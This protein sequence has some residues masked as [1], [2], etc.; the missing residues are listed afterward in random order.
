[1]KKNF[2]AAAMACI[3][4]VSCFETEEMITINADKS[5]TY[6]VT[7][8]MQGMMQQLSALAG[9]EITAGGIKEIR[10][11]VIYLRE[12]ADTSTSLTAEQKALL[13]DAK[14]AVHVDDT[15]DL[16]QFSINLPFA[17][18]DR[19]PQMKQQ[20]AQAMQQSKLA[21]QVM[22]APGSGTQ[23][24]SNPDLLGNPFDSA[25][26]WSVNGTTI[27]NVL[28]DSSYINTIL[29]GNESLA[30]MQQMAMLMGEISYITT[31]QL[32]EPVKDYTGANTWLS[33]D[34]KTIRFR[35]G[36]TELVEKPR[37]LEYSF[38]Y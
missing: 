26:S 34:K 30:S 23:T 6:T 5:G 9:S 11:T 37:V 27:S 17:H 7:L 24:G 4:L 21:D 36:I 33:D 19:L 13:R 14:M 15:E 38:T 18:I 22:G 16:M 8:R 32:P 35:A 12:M 25:F 2:I 1:M 31:Y 29:A 28:R 20:L 10:D 3:L